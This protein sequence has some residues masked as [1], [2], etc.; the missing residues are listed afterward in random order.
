MLAILAV[1][2][3]GYVRICLIPLAGTAKCFTNFLDSRQYPFALAH[4]D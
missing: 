2:R 1:S 4:P 3:F